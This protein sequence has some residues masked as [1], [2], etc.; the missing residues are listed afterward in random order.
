MGYLD[1][2]SHPEAHISHLFRDNHIDFH[3]L[4]IH[5][6]KIMQFFIS[7]SFLTIQKKPEEKIIM[8]T[9]MLLQVKSEFV[10]YKQY[11]D[12]P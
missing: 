8:W 3:I 5:V 2:V 4:Q 10:N 7:C 1:K 6:G 9:L 11:I 12:K